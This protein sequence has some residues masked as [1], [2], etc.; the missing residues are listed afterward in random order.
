MARASATAA[1]SSFALHDDKDAEPIRLVTMATPFIQMFLQ[2]PESSAN[3]S[4][5]RLAIIAWVTF[6]LLGL[7]TIARLAGG[8]GGGG[9]VVGLSACLLVACLGVL[10][11]PW[12][13]LGQP[14][15]GDERSKRVLRLVEA[16]M[17]PP[18]KMSPHELLVLRGVE[19]EAGLTLAVGAF[20]ARLA[21]L[22]ATIDDRPQHR[23]SGLWVLAAL[24]IAVLAELYLKGDV[25]VIGITALVMLGTA[26]ILITMGSLACV[27]C[28]G[29]HGRELLAGGLVCEVGSATCALRLTPADRPRSESRAWIYITQWCNV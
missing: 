13:L 17:V 18:G 20:G 28:K 2:Y 4:Y 3:K 10:S 5:K 14:W 27:A 12:V 29:S 15:F 25:G 6:L 26:L 8:F 11:T 22:L 19:D 24:G 23:L 1:T 9:S 7:L 16:C 21:Y